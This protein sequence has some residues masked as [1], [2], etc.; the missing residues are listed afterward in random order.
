MI[1]RSGNQVANNRAYRLRAI[2]HRMDDGAVAGGRVCQGQSAHSGI[3]CD[4]GKRA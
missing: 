4:F 1:A 2:R 3:S